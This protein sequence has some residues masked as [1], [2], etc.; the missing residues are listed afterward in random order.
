MTTY[1]RFP[2]ETNPATLAQEVFDYI[3][4]NAPLWIPQEGNLDVWIIRAVAQLASENR[5][6][7]SDVQ[8]DIFRFFGATIMGISPAEAVPA[9]GFTTWTLIDTLGHTIRA[10]TNVV[11]RNSF[12]D[13]IPFTVETEVIVPPGNS[14][15]GAGE[16]VIVAVDSGLDSNDLGGVG[17]PIELIDVIDWVDTAV[18]TAATA[19][20]VDEEDDSAYLNRLVGRIRRLSL[21]PVLPEDFSALAVDA[22]PTVTRAITIDGYNPGDDT[23]NN[24]RMVT[25][26]ALESDGTGVS[27]GVKTIVDNFLQANREVNFVVNVI[28]PSY[29]T[30]NVTTTVVADPG[31]VSADVQAAVEA[32]INN[33]L[34]PANWGSDPSTTEGLGTPGTWIETPVLYYNELLKEISNAPG[35]A[36][37]TALS[38]N[39]GTAN[40]NLTTPAALTNIG[41]V[42]VTVT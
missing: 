37:L 29:T 19:G 10:G 35:V 12:G 25:V 16:V 24:E 36:R 4:T 8:D 26:A 28:D 13:P 39:G 7:A 34:S 17:E 14:V 9:R 1:I 30:I 18:L 33:Y 41:T 42:S 15:T 38:V 3:T 40:I 11:I 20:G 23:Y 5:D 31:T 21:R 32:A 22:D 2:L 6:I 27:G